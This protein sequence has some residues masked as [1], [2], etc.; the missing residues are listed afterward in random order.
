MCAFV[1]YKVYNC[2]ALGSD[3]NNTNTNNR[4]LKSRKILFP[5]CLKSMWSRAKFQI[6]HIESFAPL[7]TVITDYM[8]GG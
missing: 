4:H 8:T 1:L 3:S 7:S 6:S 2:K 5:K